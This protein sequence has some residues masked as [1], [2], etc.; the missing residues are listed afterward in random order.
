M[1]VRLHVAL[2]RAGCGSRRACE[3]LIRDGV[4]AVNGAIVSTMGTRIDDDDRVTVRGKSIRGPQALRYLLLNKPRAVVSTV[5]DP[6]GRRTV[7]DFVTTA[8]E[9]LY[10]VGRL[11]YHSEGLIILTNDGELADILLHPRHAVPRVYLARIRGQMLPEEVALLAK[12]IRLGGKPTG[13]ILVRGIRKRGATSEKSHWVE[14]TVTE[15][16]Y[17]LVR[18]ALL[19]VGHPVSRLRRVAFGPLKLGRLEPGEIRELT[20][21]EIAGLRAA[22]TTGAPSKA[23]RI[24]SR[25][26]AKGAAGPGARR[27]ISRKRPSS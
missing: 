26:R 9:R 12:G 25:A 1:S 7:L 11:D 23:V 13:A 2:A 14:V 19:R 16:R 10:P 15:G 20:Q 24:G 5:S 4:V 3:Q 27:K 6:E 18:E 21:A 22:G 17:H 8:R